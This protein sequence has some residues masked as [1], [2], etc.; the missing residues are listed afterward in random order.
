MI[1]QRKLSIQES[2]LYVMKIMFHNPLPCRHINVCGDK[3]AYL[4][5]IVP[6]LEIIEPCFRIVVITPIAERVIRAQCSCQGAG[7]GEDVSL[8]THNFCNF[9]AFTYDFYFIHIY[10]QEPNSKRIIIPLPTLF[11]ELMF[12][13]LDKKVFR[14]F[15]RNFFPSK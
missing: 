10:E 11:Q 13:L 15:I 3:P 9:D 8:L 12:N 7:R 1:I 4:G 2:F 14:K 5:V 6:R